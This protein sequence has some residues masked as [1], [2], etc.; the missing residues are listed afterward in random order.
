VVIHASDVDEYSVA[1]GNVVGILI[2]GMKELNAKLEAA[3][4]QIEN[5]KQLI[6]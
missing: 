1:Y 4:T 5:L 2:E 6:K 3:N